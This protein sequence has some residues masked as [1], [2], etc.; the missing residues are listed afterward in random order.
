M[1][2]LPPP[3]AQLP[4]LLA[5]LPAP[6][7]SS[8]ESLPLSPTSDAKTT[9]RSR[10]HAKSPKL[11]SSSDDDSSEAKAPKRKPKRKGS[12]KSLL[13]S[14]CSLARSC[15]PSLAGLRCV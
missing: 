1:A 14:T 5:S 9:P 8:S 11:S 15:R 2:A 13:S 10:R 7:V 12:G 3:I 4:T 6:L